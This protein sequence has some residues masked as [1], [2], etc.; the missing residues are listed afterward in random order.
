MLPRA[1]EVPCGN[2]E[3]G[4]SWAKRQRFRQKNAG[5]CGLHSRNS[6]FC[7][8]RLHFK[9]FSYPWSNVTIMLVLRRERTHLQPE[10]VE[11]VVTY[12][13]LNFPGFVGC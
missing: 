2:G 4:R 3:A 1:R 11:A 8:E 13:L 7:S 6:N 10:A 9:R 5:R 12:S